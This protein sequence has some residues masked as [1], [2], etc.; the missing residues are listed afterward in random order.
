MEDRLKFKNKFREKM[1]GL[2]DEIDEFSA[3]TQAQ[4]NY[5]FYD[6]GVKNKP[7]NKYKTRFH[8]FEN[9]TDKYSEEELESI[10]R[11]K[12][13]EFMERS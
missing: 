12:R 1:I 2:F 3:R 7:K 13:E 9:R 10:V 6:N 4:I 8:N 11:R 5:D